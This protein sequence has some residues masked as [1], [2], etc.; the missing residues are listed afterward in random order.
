MMLEHLKRP[1][2]SQVVNYNRPLLPPSTLFLPCSFETKGKF[3]LERSQIISSGCILRPPAWLTWV[4]NNE[5]TK[6]IKQKD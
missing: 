6:R 5:N 4:H 1:F 2:V 3:D